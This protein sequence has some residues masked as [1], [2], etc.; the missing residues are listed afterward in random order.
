MS[1]LRLRRSLPILVVAL[2]CSSD[3]VPGPTTD[4]YAVAT[5]AC[6][7]ADGPAVGIYLAHAPVESLEPPAPYFRVYIWEWLDR[8]GG[9][10]W[11]LGPNEGKGGAWFHPTATDFEIATRGTVTVTAVR[12]DST[13]EGR[14]DLTF[15]GGTRLSGTFRAGWRSRQMLCG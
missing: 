13:V 6:G 9:R 1:V 12:P 3:D 11:S 2:A 5:A 15:P 14:A 10:S 7:P 4:L 8:L